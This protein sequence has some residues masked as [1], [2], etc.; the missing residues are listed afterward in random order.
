MKPGTKIQAQS[1][2]ELSDRPK[3]QPSRVGPL[4]APIA[5]QPPST[6]LS[7]PMPHSPMTEEPKSVLDGTIDSP[8][9]DNCLIEMDFP[10][11][12]RRGK[13][14]P[15]IVIDKYIISCQEMFRKNLDDMEV[16]QCKNER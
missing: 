12:E 5:E 3:I 13:G 2:F 4:S 11:K 16:T 1:Q 7:A 10:E 6:N 9:S 15:A 8:S 14:K